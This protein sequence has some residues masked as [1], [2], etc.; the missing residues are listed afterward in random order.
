MIGVAV[1]ADSTTDRRSCLHVSLTPGRKLPGVF[2]CSVKSQ[3]HRSG[4][5]IGAE[6]YPRL[7]ASRLRGGHKSSGD[8]TDEGAQEMAFHERTEGVRRGADEQAIACCAFVNQFPCQPAQK[9][10]PEKREASLPRRPAIAELDEHNP[11]KQACVDAAEPT[12]DQDV[13][14]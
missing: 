4:K 7:V 13:G 9:D 1:L 11:D 10:T 14:T 12:I 3:S 5:P 6:E 8:S 2:L